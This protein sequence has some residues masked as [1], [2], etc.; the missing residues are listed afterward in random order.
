MFIETDN[1][2]NARPQRGRMFIET[3]DQKMHD[4]REVECL[5]DFLNTFRMC[6]TFHQYVLTVGGI[7]RQYEKN[8]EYFI[9]FTCGDVAC[10]VSTF[11]R[12]LFMFNNLSH[13]QVET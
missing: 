11:V 10:Y 1:Q 4:L 3:D 12:N 13:L 2:K 5:V 7:N 8:A 9:V 6:S